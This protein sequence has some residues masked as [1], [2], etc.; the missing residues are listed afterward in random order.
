MLTQHIELDLSPDAL[1]EW[2]TQRAIDAIGVDTIRKACDEAIADDSPGEDPKIVFTRL[3]K[4][5][6]TTKAHSA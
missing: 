5:Y 4:R 1:R 2:R 3:R 6:S